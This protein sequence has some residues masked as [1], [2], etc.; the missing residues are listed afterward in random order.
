MGSTL[1]ET[2]NINAKDFTEH[3]LTCSTCI[4]QYSS[5][6]H[7]HQPKLLPCSHTVCRQCLEHIVNSQP[8]SDAIKCPICREHILLPRGGVTSFPPSFLVNQLLD[9]MVSQRRDVIPKCDSH[10]NEELLFCETCD[11]IF[12]QLCDQ[13]Q[14]SAEHTVVP[15]SLAIKRMNEILSFKA[16][17]TT[18]CLDHALE[19]VNN[20]IQRL[21][22][23]MEKAAEAIDRSFNEIK[24]YVEHRRHN[25]L[26]SLKTTK[27]Y[28]LKVLNDQLNVIL[29]EKSK[30]ELE[31]AAFQQASDIHVLTQRIQEL[32]DR[33]ERM[34]LL[35]EPRENSFM[36]FEFR[37]NQALQDLARSLNSVGR[38]R[39]SSTYPPLCRAKIE[40]PVANLQCA[41]QIETV[42]YNGN[43]RVD[44]GDPLTVNIWDSYGKLCEY[45]LYD[46]QSGAYT[47]IFRPLISGNHKID[48]RIFD[49]PISGSPFTVDV[50]KHNNPLWTFGKR[51][52][53][54]HELSM[55][56]SVIVDN[57]NEREQVYILDPGN[58]R[59][60]CLTVDGKFIE[61]LVVDSL[62][63]STSTGLAYRSSTS[64]FYLLDWKSKFITEFTLFNS[65]SSSA[66]VNNSRI[67][68]NHQVTCS[69]FNEPV[70]IALFEQHFNS[71]L[72]CDNN[73][74][75]IIDSR[76]GDLIN[77]IDIRSFG[78][79]TIKAFTVGLQDEII[80]SDHRI[81]VLSYEG[82]YIRQISSVNQQQ[83]VDVDI[84]ITHEPPDLIASHH[85]QSLTLPQHTKSVNSQ[86]TKGGFYTA[87][88]VDKNGLLLAGKCEKD[89][90]AHIEIYDNQ[91]HLLR[92]IDS[93][94]QR[95]RR[96]CSLATTQ[97][98]CVLC[99]DLT[100]DSVRKYRYA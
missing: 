40:A 51:G 7:E 11:K 17:K 4:N 91:G 84:H 39:V 21:D 27:D 3:F 57:R 74:L 61:H 68:I 48:I 76:T 46:K 49:R 59:I 62:V 93:Y 82:K 36:K 1:V 87:L 37:H 2:I 96:P 80:L 25:L 32:N 60:K 72:I 99:V 26:Q 77:K 54:E 5:D 13:H 79:K 6:S 16:S 86:T 22:S 94:N 56:V 19:L 47:I 33:I 30:I 29:N 78:I 81:H 75:L 45:D 31:C 64:T 70:Q 67:H 63:E 73:T 24:S 9:L 58:S 55:P 14:I 98:G 42:D 97:D 44:G 88:C 20:E 95:L 71:L 90:N 66:H 89:G 53:G 10:T 83:I 18:S 50:T 8:R 34:S 35:G 100:T 69:L 23:S 38:I 65:N 92:I 85:K 52:R 41:I 28:K 12:C 15:F 43:I